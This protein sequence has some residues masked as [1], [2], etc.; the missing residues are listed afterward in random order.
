MD[1]GYAIFTNCRIPR[2]NML[3]RYS[4]VTRDGRYTKPPHD[5]LVY[6]GMTYARINIIESSAHSLSRA[7]TIAIR[8]CAVRR[9]GSASQV[10]AGLSEPPVLDY[11]SVQY[12]LFPL[13][14]ATY[15]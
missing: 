10:K 4:Q 9:Q 5:K 11:P 15:A 12:R 1:N 6:G 2:T 7:V 13:L 8:Y 14:A 3:M